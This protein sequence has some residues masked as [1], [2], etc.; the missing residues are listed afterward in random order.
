MISFRNFSCGCNRCCNNNNNCSQRCDCNDSCPYP[1]PPPEP[2][3]CCC[4]G[5]RGPQGPVGPQG[6]IGA[7]GAQGPQGPI[8]PVGPTG[9]TGAMGA[10]GPQG[11]AGLNDSAYATSGAQTLTAESLIPLTF[12]RSST[13]SSMTFSGGQFTVPAGL[14]IVSYSADATTPQSITL[15]INGTPSTTETVTDLSTPSSVSRT[16]L[17]SMGNAGTIGLYNALSGETVSLNSA[18]LV[19]TKIE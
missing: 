1:P 16:A 19:L 5:P 6:P 2:P 10:T 4:V 17:I 18:A 11:P 3:S 15:A 9:A 12:V 8:G 13:N 7:T 14:Y